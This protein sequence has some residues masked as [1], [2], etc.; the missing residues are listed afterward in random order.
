MESTN[1]QEL[2]EASYS[3]S[4]ISIAKSGKWQSH[5]W[6]Y[7]SPKGN[8]IIVRMILPHFVRRRCELA[9]NG[10]RN[11]SSIIHVV[12][13]GSQKQHIRIS[14]LRLYFMGLIRRKEILLHISIIDDFAENIQSIV[15]AMRLFHIFF[16][17]FSVLLSNTFTDIISQIDSVWQRRRWLCSMKIDNM[18]G[19]LWWLIHFLRNL[20]RYWRYITR[21]NL[22]FFERNNSIM[23]VLMQ[24]TNFTNRRTFNMIN[25]FVITKSTIFINTPEVFW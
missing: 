3:I 13:I 9:L 18:P 25:V 21:G 15:I 10:V 1:H 22:I 19:H 6:R 8:Q 5:L 16:R 20:I 4:S 14:Q 2:I 24:L 12:L 17:Y 11:I 23:A 7:I